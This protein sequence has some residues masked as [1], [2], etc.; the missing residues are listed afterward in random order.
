MANRLTGE[1]R[2]LCNTLS[3]TEHI[4]LYLVVNQETKC[5]EWQGST[6]KD[7]YGKI[8]HRHKT[9]RPHRAI[10]EDYFSMKLLPTQQ[11]N[12]TCDN[13]KCCNALHL[14]AG[15]Q[16]QNIKDR[17][18]RNRQ[19]RGTKNANNKWS[20]DQ[21]REVRKLRDEGNSLQKIS[22]ITKIPKGTV[23]MIV[24]KRNWRWLE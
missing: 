7:G 19:A 18:S 16:Q 8:T 13:R 9:I 3:L 4:N 10:Y 24:S 23:S 5:R 17:D 2:K 22:D 21:V 15:T 11:L 14:Y 1:R 12:H 20:E 6:D